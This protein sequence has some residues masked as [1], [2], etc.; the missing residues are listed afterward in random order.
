MSKQEELPHGDLVAAVDNFKNAFEQ[1]RAKED[2]K[3]EPEKPKQKQKAEIVQL[4]L[5]NREAPAAPNAA[6]RSALFPAIQGKDRRMLNN[7]IIASVGG[8][9]VRLKGEQLNQ[10]DLDSLLVLENVAREHPDTLTCQISERG[11]LKMLGRRSGKTNEKALADSL[12]RLEQPITVKMGRFSYSGGFVHHIYKDDL[13]KRYVVQLNERL[14]ALLRTGWTAL[15]TRI[16]R[17]LAGKSLALWLQAFYAS[18]DKPFAYSVEKLRELSGGR[19]AQLKK[20]R[21]NLKKALSD[22]A[23]TGDIQGWKIDP[24]T[25]FVHI[26]KPKKISSKPRP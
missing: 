5:W 8:V 11:L 13:T 16:R 21:Q 23:A 25:D 26:T 3:P 4:P 18:H 12:L 1:R 17:Q 9:E 20:F 14:G 7:E 24:A 22:W 19:T 15:D 10:D 2:V 6:L